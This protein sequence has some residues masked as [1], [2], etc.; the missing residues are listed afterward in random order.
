MHC[1]IWFSVFQVSQSTADL[2]AAVSDRIARAFGRSQATLQLL[3]LIY[4]RLLTRSALLVPFTNLSLMEFQVR[5][6]ALF[7]L[8]SVISSSVVLDKRPS[9]EYPVN[10]G[11][12]QGSILS[13]TLFLLYIN[14]LPDDVI[15][16]RWVK[17]NVP[18]IHSHISKIKETFWQKA[19]HSL[20]Y[21]PL[22]FCRP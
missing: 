3:H 17:N 8:F 22:S 14:E 5:S 6:L 2:R 10:A 16:T 11:V 19:F 18:K 12:L 13:P 15:Y 7:L 4:P 1:F 9:Q 20:Y 21:K